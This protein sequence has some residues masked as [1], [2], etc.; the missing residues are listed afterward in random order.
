MR[1]TAKVVY[2]PP[3]LG[4]VRDLYSSSSVHVKEVW[5]VYYT[6]GKDS[7]KLLSS[8]I[9]SPLVLSASPL[10]NM[11]GANCVYYKN[12]CGHFIVI[13]SL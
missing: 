7:E 3:L 13:G 5:I 2:V 4:S 6:V 10:A 12:E 8:L 9:L 1:G 11:K